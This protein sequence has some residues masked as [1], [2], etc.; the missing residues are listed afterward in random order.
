[1]IS[2]IRLVTFTAIL[3]LIFFVLPVNANTPAET[4][5][6]MGFKDNKWQLFYRKTGDLNFKRIKTA[7]EPRELYFSPH[8]QRIFYLDAETRLRQLILGEKQKEKVLF[9]P[10]EN[11]S[12][13]QLFWDRAGSLLYMVKMPHGK[14]SEAD[15]VVWHKGKIKPVVRQISSQFEPFVYNKDWLYYG[16]VHCSLDCGHIIQEIWRKNLI[17][18]E[19]EQISLLGQISRQAVVDSEGKWVYFSSNKQGQ[20]HIWRQAL[21]GVS[22]QNKGCKLCSAQQITKGNVTDTD[23]AI[24]KEGEIFFIRHTQGKAFLM[25]YKKEGVLKRI[26]L[27]EGVSEIRNLRI[28]S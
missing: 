19:A 18:G 28:N 1:M 5:Y 16:H 3:M 17:S 27:P 4:L 13:A 24:N 20:Y 14:S 22:S 7:S 21:S 10:S 25:N 26:A 15:I 2:E 6:F 12:Y 9:S 11:D 23:P 8:E